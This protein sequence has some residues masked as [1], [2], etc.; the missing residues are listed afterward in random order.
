MLEPRHPRPRI[1]LPKLLVDALELL[2]SGGRTSGEDSSADDVVDELVDGLAR[3]QI[4]H[5]TV[6]VLHVPSNVNLRIG[7]G[8]VG[9][10]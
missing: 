6:Q 2:H 5:G 1:R 7:S 9:V 10:F 8:M 3:D 4:R